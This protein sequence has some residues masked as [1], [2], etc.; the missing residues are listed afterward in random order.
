LCL[1]NLLLNLW[2]KISLQSLRYY[3]PQPQAK[4]TPRMLQ[5]Q[6]LQPCRSMLAHLELHLPQ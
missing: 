4:A 2:A 6:I 3:L 1:L 5:I